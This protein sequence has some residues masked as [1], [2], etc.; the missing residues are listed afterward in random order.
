M[1]DPK[2]Q[3]RSFN[4]I[5]NSIISNYEFLYEA[6]YSLSERECIAFFNEFFYV[7]YSKQNQLS[8]ERYNEI[9]YKKKINID[10]SLTQPLAIMQYLLFNEIKENI[11]NNG[12]KDTLRNRDI[13]I[14]NAKN[15]FIDNV[16]TYYLQG[17]IMGENKINQFL[18]KKLLL[19]WIYSNKTIDNESKQKITKIINQI[20]DEQVPV[21]E[22]A[23]REKENKEKYRKNFVRELEK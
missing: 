15:N 9:T 4:N 23:W 11:K 7:L 22:N 3:N 17:E 19:Y 14:K 18:V 2:R 12:F 10:I 13:I 1:D 6:E 5:F 8:F 20:S 16:L 21:D